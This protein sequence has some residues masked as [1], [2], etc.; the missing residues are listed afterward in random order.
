M[1]KLLY[2][3]FEKNC[4]PSTEKPTAQDIF[5]QLGAMKTLERDITST[6]RIY[7]ETIIEQ[8]FLECV[9]IWIWRV[10]I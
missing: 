4:V 8:H 2:L 7:L 1:T 3:S 9:N 6:T 5:N 10:V